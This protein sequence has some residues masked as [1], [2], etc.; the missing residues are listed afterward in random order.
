MAECSYLGTLADQQDL[1]EEI[2][3]LA[4]E[5][6]VVVAAAEPTVA[7]VASAAGVAPPAA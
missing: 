1:A 7:P 3:H 4:V 6:A 5:A 2:E